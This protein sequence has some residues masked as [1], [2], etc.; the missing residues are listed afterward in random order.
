MSTCCFG[1]SGVKLF[2]AVHGIYTTPSKVPSSFTRPVRPAMIFVSRY[3][4][5]T[6]S[7]IA[8]V[9]STPK[10]SWILPQSDFAPSL[11]KISS[12]SISTIPRSV[13]RAVS[14]VFCFNISALRRNNSFVVSVTSRCICKTFCCLDKPSA[15]T[16]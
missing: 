2:S 15:I 9:L 16:I 10:I 5:Y 13:S 4:G 3:T 1:S 8:I 11:T 12:V 7:V 6:G 14:I